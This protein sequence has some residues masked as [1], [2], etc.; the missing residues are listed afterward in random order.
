MPGLKSLVIAAKD[1]RIRLRDRRAAVVLLAMPMVLIF[2]LGLVFNP[3][4]QGTA[5]IQAIPLVVVDNDHGEIARLLVDEVLRTGIVGRLLRVD[6]A[7]RADAARALVVG[8]RRTAALIIPEGFSQAVMT[9]RPTRL[10]LYTDPAQ[11]I[12]AGIVRS[13]VNRL[14]AEI[15]R[16]QVAITVAAE[17][18]ITE[19]VM[20]PRQVFAAIPGWLKDIEKFVG[21][22]AVA[23]AEERGTGPRIPAAMDYYAVAM[24]VVYILFGVSMASQSIL[25]E[26]REGTLARL[27]TTPT[28]SADIVAGKLLAT[29]LTGLAQFTLLV[30]FTRVLY[31]VRWGS[32]LLL[33]VMITATALAAAGLGTLVA[34]LARS[35]EAAEAVAPALILPMSFL[36]GS[37]YPI[38][39][40][41]P[42]LDAVSRLTFNRWA[43]DGFLAVMG[44]E[45]SHAAIARPVV[46][47]LAMGLVSMVIGTRRL[48]FR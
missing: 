21:R 10:T 32:P 8:G 4:W 14:T 28:A 34:A 45:T 35:P 47:L 3:L 46:V 17:T 33:L 23:I 19:Q 36:G 40:M 16:R 24:G 9:G 5:E 48:R 30:I 2:I 12:R 15:V 37:M 29:F 31:G 43:L 26:R 41:P 22:E 1:L 18:L 7:G 44:G 27:R 6:R 11:S 42:W 39:V 13:I 20:T 25:V 38:Y